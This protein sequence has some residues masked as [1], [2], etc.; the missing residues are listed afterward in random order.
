[1][2]NLDQCIIDKAMES[3]DEE[4][5]KGTKNK[6]NC[7]GF[8]KSVAKKLGIP[9]PDTANADGIV[10]FMASSWKKLKSGEEA[11]RLASTGTFVL[12]GLK[13]SEHAPARNNGHV[14]IVVSGALYKQKYPVVWGGSTGGAQSQGDKTV[15]EVWNTKDRDNVAYYAYSIAVCKK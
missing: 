6:N 1:M 8:V 5:I 3:W 10:D 7:S 13:G 12:A 11:A 4:F 2:A 9:L 14:A 15:G